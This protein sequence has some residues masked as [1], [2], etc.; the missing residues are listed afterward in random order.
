MLLLI[1]SQHLLSIRIVHLFL[2]WELRLASS[3]VSEMCQGKISSGKIPVMSHSE[4]RWVCTS[5]RNFSAIEL[6]KK[7]KS[8]YLSISGK[9]FFFKSIKHQKNVVYWFSFLEKLNQ[10]TGFL[11]FLIPLFLIWLLFI[12]RE[13]TAIFFSFCNYVYLQKQ[14]FI[15]V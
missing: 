10:L 8:N 1:F 7:M 6:S 13:V 12:L 2:T 4:D 14:L 3:Y 15:W 11:S 9:H 5:T